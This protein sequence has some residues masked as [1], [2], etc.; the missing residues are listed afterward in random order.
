MGSQKTEENIQTLQT[1]SLRQNKL[2]LCSASGRKRLGR[3]AGLLLTSALL[4]NKINVEC[5]K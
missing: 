2:M 1:N 3:G 5:K 4:S